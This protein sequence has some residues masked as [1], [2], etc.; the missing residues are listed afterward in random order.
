MKVERCESARVGRGIVSKSISVKVQEE[1]SLEIETC[2]VGKQMQ[3]RP[4]LASTFQLGAF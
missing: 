1:E 2:K 4:L 3:D